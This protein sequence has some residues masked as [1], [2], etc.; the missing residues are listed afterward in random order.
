MAGL[1]VYIMGPSGAGK[2]SLIDAA[3][4]AL[5]AAG[6]HVA[7][8]VITRSAESAGEQAVGVSS[9]EFSKRLQSGAFALHWQANGLDYGITAD[10]SEKLARGESVLVNG[11][12]AHLPLA[13]Q[14]YAHCLPIL[15][16]VDPG[17]L[18]ERLLRRGRESL[19]Q[20]E[21]RLARS[22]QMPVVDQVNGVSIERLDNSADLQAG[23]CRL[24]QLLRQYGVAAAQDLS[25]AADRT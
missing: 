18:R 14:A 9:E 10:M 8:R 6:V 4:P 17:V 1:L 3:R 7:R 2:D 12:R 20:I 16:E 11:S 25:A 5:Q 21:Q 23:V 15:V 24:L 22:A 13:L 19:E